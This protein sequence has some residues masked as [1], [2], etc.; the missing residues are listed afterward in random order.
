VTQPLQQC[1]P[2]DLDRSLEPPP[3]RGGP[4]AYHQTAVRTAVSPQRQRRVEA[5]ELGLD[6]P[7]PPQPRT[8]N[9]LVQRES[10]PIGSGA[11]REF[12]SG[13]T[14]EGQRDF[15]FNQIRQVTADRGLVHDF[16]RRRSPRPAFFL[17]GN[18]VLDF[19]NRRAS[20]ASFSGR[21]RS[22]ARTSLEMGICG[23]VFSG[24]FGEP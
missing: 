22:A 19:R 11:L 5:V 14:G 23:G 21:W 12:E 4:Q 9:P 8:K 16:G 3:A 10:L 6:E 7:V 18:H 15:G 13:D 2:D 20:R 1:R 24:F 17:F